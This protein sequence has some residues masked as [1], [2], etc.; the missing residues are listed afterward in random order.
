MVLNA[1]KFYG[2][3]LASCVPFLNG[4][5]LISGPQKARLDVSPALP[6]AMFVL[7]SDLP[8][9][10]NKELFRDGEFA[11]LDD[12]A[13]WAALV[14]EAM[15]AWNTA[16]GSYLRFELATGTATQDPL[17][18]VHSI[19]VGDL[20]VTSA[21]VA[22]PQVE[23]SRILDCDILI[24]TA[25]N[26]AS[27]L[28]FALMHELGHCVGLGHNHSN[29][30]AAMGYSRSD[31]SLRLG[32]D[33][34]AGVAFLYPAVGSE[35]AKEMI[36]CG[37]VAGSNATAWSLFPLLLVPLF[38]LAIHSKVNGKFLRR[39]PVAAKI[40]L[41]SAGARGGTAGSPTPPTALPVVTTLVS[42]LGHS[43]ILKRG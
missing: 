2:A 14:T 28:A 37:T 39:L 30:N 7:A 40:A 34:I 11:A 27:E 19:T 25:T 9:V 15:K 33:D 26:E 24:G 10:K 23:G 18:R 31:R 3:M 13:F 43:D 22:M 38:A 36:A 29:Y 21:A 20:G 35:P 42:I 16:P 17:D 5:V 1:T 41:A 32:A 8:E 12:D 4:F 6:T